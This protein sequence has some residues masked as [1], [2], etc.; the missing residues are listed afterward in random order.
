MLQPTNL[1]HSLGD[2]VFVDLNE[3]ELANGG[4]HNNAT[5]QNNIGSRTCT[6]KHGFTGDGINMCNGKSMCGLIMVSKTK[7]IK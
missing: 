2:L 6:C 3:C 4:C 7:S 5:C 1:I